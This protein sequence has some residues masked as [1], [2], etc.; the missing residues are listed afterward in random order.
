MALESSIE[1][2][3]RQ[4]VKSEGGYYIKLSPQWMAGIPDRML[5]L[6]NATISFIEIKRPDGTY[7]PKQPY[8]KKRLQ[9]LG[10]RVYTTWDGFELMQ[11]VKQEIEISNGKT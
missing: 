11:I 8:I 4:L 5:L 9:E 10:F 6:K 1:A 2:K 3:P 7:R